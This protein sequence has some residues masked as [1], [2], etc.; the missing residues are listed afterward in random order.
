MEPVK[1]GM[2]EMNKIMTRLVKEKYNKSEKGKACRK[3]YIEKNKEINA[4]W[5]TRAIVKKKIQEQTELVSVLP[6][7]N[8][9]KQRYTKLLSYNI[10][11]LQELN[12]KI[13]LLKPPK[14]E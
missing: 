10:Q 3:R 4:L 13:A 1:S 9:L 12:D 5:V 7:E 6:E 11:R 8:K 2:D 14:T